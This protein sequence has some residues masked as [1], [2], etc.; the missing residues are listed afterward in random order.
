MEEPYAK[1]VEMGIVKPGDVAFM[2][3]ETKK[4]ED[5]MDLSHVVIF[6]RAT[7]PYL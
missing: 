1:I 5:E 6:N 3:T 7:V 4:K 2:A